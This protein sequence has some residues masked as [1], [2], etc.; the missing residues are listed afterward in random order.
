M[1]SHASHSEPPAYH[2]KH[3]F[4][5]FCRHPW[6]LAWPC[7]TNLGL[8]AARPRPSSPS[9]SA[10]GK[11]SPQRLHNSHRTP[12]AT[13]SQSLHQQPTASSVRQKPPQTH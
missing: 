9:T 8:S 11:S 13:V 1:N 3:G 2:H 7:A 5:V 4:Q 6:L 12:P 10:G